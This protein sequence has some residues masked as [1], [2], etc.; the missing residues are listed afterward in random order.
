M[1]VMP[2]VMIVEAMAQ[3]GGIV[4]H[5]VTPEELSNSHLFFLQ[6]SK[7]LDFVIQ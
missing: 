7:N 6:G 4:I 1:A 3:V 5:S 2:G